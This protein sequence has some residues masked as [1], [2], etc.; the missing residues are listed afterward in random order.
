MHRCA[1]AYRCDRIHTHSLSHTHT[2]T[3][4]QT[5]AHTGPDVAIIS[6]FPIKAPV[7][8]RVSHCSAQ[9]HHTH[10]HC[11]LRCGSV[12]LLCVHRIYGAIIH[13]AVSTDLHRPSCSAFWAIQHP[14]TNTPCRCK[15]C[16]PELIVYVRNTQKI[17]SESYLLRAPR[18]CTQT[19]H[20]HERTHTHKHTHTPPP[21]PP[22]PPPP[23]SVPSP[24]TP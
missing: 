19:T 20:T 22:P 18:K 2:H 8:V 3:H 21:P 6:E 17:V 11:A 15:K 10:T 5:H 23:H 9:E 4:T 14:V 12:P 24:P 16:K 7:K 13:A 1:H